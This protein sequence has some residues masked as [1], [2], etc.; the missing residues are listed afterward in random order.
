[1]VLSAFG[2][3][4]VMFGSDWPVCLLASDYAGVVTLARSLTAG[5]SAAERAAVFGETAARA[6]QLGPPASGA[7]GEAGRAGGAGGIR[8]ATGQETGQGTGSWH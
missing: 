4:R 8:M 3:D 7:T 2:A 1:V 6:Y 5:L